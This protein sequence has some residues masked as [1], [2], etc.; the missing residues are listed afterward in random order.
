MSPRISLAAG[1]AGDHQHTMPHKEGTAARTA[2]G[3]LTQLTAHSSWFW[4]FTGKDKACFLQQASSF[5]AWNLHYVCHSAISSM[6]RTIT[7][8]LPKISKACGNP[9]LI[10]EMFLWS[11]NH[12]GYKS[13]IL[14]E[15]QSWNSLFS[16]QNKHYGWCNDQTPVMQWSDLVRNALEEPAGYSCGYSWGG[17]GPWSDPHLQ[18]GRRKQGSKEKAVVITK[19]Q[20][21]T[22][23]NK[24]CNALKSA[25]WFQEAGMTHGSWVTGHVEKS[26]QLNRAE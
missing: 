8:Q 17:R 25:G 7:H 16:R 6:N 19:Y 26:I 24:E 14:L 12:S 2:L 13:I 10:S 4:R 21:T 11:R 1:A 15:W 18:N 20:F 9:N 22:F 3:V 5:L 23:R